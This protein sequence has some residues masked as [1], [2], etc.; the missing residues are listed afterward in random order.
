MSSQDIQDGLAS[1]LSMIDHPLA[2]MATQVVKEIYSTMATQQE[3][4][5][6][7]KADVARI[8]EVTD[9]LSGLLPQ[10][11]LSLSTLTDANTS[12]Q[13]S[14]TADDAEIAQLKTATGAPIDLAAVQADLDD[15]A[16]KLEGLGSVAPAS[17]ATLAST[18]DTTPSAAM[19]PVPPTEEP[20]SSASTTPTEEPP[21]SSGTPATTD[22]SGADS[23]VTPAAEQNR[24]GH[25]H[26][27][28]QC[29]YRH[30]S[31]RR[32]G[33]RGCR[34]EHVRRGIASTAYGAG[35]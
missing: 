27:G 7:I 31:D 33:C 17:P 28:D 20:T 16:G 21:A 26:R 13:T 25:R 29:D 1:A 23:P 22:G 10:M 35:A 14:L 30:H 4:V 2:T 3:Q 8:K 34:H 18:T 6:A 11:R 5:D 32:A 24:H 12:L 9:V 15:I 19:D